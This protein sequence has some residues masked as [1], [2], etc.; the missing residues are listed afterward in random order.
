M[1]TTFAQH[2][3]LVVRIAKLKIDPEKLNEYQAA[4]KEEIE[5]SVKYEPGVLSLNAV[6]DRNKSN[7][8]T[9][10]EIYASEEAYRKHLE[11]PHFKKYK[12]GTLNFVQSLE[13]VETDPIILKSKFT[14]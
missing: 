3:Q 6:A 9:I 1:Q 13:L 7:E 5:A 12:T 14:N 10:L 8:I 2:N 4:L 11:T